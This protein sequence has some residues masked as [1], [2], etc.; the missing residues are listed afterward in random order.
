MKTMMQDGEFCWNAKAERHD[1]CISENFITSNITLKSTFVEIT[2]YR[3]EFLQL[4]VSSHL[5][6]LDFNIHIIQKPTEGVFTVL[7][8]MTPQ[9]YFYIQLAH[10]FTEA[11]QQSWELCSHSVASLEPNRWALTTLT[12]LPHESYHCTTV[13]EEIE[14]IWRLGTLVGCEDIPWG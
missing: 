12:P 6:T 7:I 5:Q 10:M 14:I 9:L 4:F 13:Q 11:L 2:V 8:S 3:S 1:T